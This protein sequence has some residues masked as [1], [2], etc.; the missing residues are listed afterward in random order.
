MRNIILVFVLLLSASMALAQRRINPFD[1]ESSFSLC[2]DRAYHHSVDPEYLGQ[3]VGH[4]EPGIGFF[5]NVPGS[6]NNVQWK[7]ILPKDPATFPTDANV[8]G[9]GGPTVW[10]FQQHT[11]FWFGMAICDTESYPEYSHT[12]VPDSDDNIYDEPNPNSKRFIG[13]HPGTAVMEMQFY[14]PGWVGSGVGD[15]AASYTA[16]QYT[17]AITIDSLN[18]Q[19]PGPTGPLRYGEGVL[20]NNACLNTVGV[21]VVNFALLTLDGKSQAPGDPLNSDPNKYSVVPGETFLMNPGDT[22]VVTIHDTMDGVRVIVQDLNTKQAGVMTASA[23]NGFAQVVFDPNATT[24]TS[25][26]YAFHPMYATSGPHTRVPWTARNYIN[27]SFTDEIGHFTYC[28]AQDNLY[29]PGLGIC[30]SSPVENEFDPVT[31]LH[32]AD[33]Q[34]CVDA[35]SSLLY[36]AA[37][38]LGGCLDA[39]GDFDGVPYH[40]AWAGS[41]PDVYGFSAVPDPVRFSSPKFRPRGDDDLISYKLIAFETDLPA[42]SPV[43]YCPILGGPGCLPPPPGAFYPF[44][45]TTINN[46]RCWW[47]LGGGAIPG[48]N[49]N[50]GGSSTTEFSNQIAPLYI[51]GTTT[52]PSAGNVIVEDAYQI[53][54]NPCK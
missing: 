37:Q 51:L 49:N 13:H 9:T 1:C 21:E 23:T 35:A 17:A 25:R 4:D 34:F 2:V 30:L 10:N 7:L 52:A 16:N 26:P 54:R 3:Y 14:P 45:T 12:C 47:Q 18:W 33:D 22:L 8:N 32:E 41:G 40:H 42:I 36:G 43:S 50:F 39:D 31:G 24:C 38:P 5:S 28:D 48:T 27:M 20:N 19:D 44:F 53:L 11:A 46:G 29:A 15:F 6:G